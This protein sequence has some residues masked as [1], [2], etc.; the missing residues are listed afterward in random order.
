MITVIPLIWYVTSKARYCLTAVNLSQF[1]IVKKNSSTLTGWK[2]PFFTVFFYFPSSYFEKSRDIVR[3]LFGEGVLVP[4]GARSQRLPNTHKRAH[5]YIS[6]V[7]RRSLWI[8][9]ERGIRHLIRSAGLV[10]LF[11]CLGFLQTNSI[12][13]SI[14]SINQ[15]WLCHSSVP[16][17][18]RVY[19]PVR[20]GCHFV[21]FSTR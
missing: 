21:P 2:F 16:D 10:I 12:V 14:P 19:L 4:G 11:L 15:F 17:C 18:Y 9:P 3:A 6:P 8:A 20:I 7:S 5:I 1:L 13:H